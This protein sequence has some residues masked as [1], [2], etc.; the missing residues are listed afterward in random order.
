MRMISSVAALAEYFKRWFPKRNIIIISERKVKHLPVGG[1]TQFV[2]LALLIFGVCWAS[3]STGSFMAARSVLK[4]QRQTLRSVASARVDTNFNTMFPTSE[5]TNVNANAP[6]NPTVTS[7]S[8]PM[9]TLSSLDHNKMFARI[10]FLEH[11]VMELKTNTDAIIRRVSD[12]TSGRISDLESVIRQTGLKVEDLKHE[13]NGGKQ[14]TEGKPAANAKSE[15]GPYIPAAMSS[16]EYAM[17]GNLDKLAV[18]RQIVGNLPLGKPIADA[19]P[20]S[21]FGHRIDPFTGHLAFH[22][23]LDLAGPTGSKIYSTAEGTVAFAGISGAYGNAV[24]IDHGFG[25]TTR[26]GHLSEIRVKEGQTVHKGDVIGI[27]GST[28]RSTGPHLHY[29]VRYHDHPMNP[30][31]FLDAGHYVSEE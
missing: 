31:N 2:T 18:L 26:Y 12:K 27:Q 5:L 30:A 13:L 9:Y 21:P 3:Y 4:E 19:E 17:Y 29:E 8:D 14:A 22:S 7:L 1:K 24:D 28:G 23:G 16:Q 15:G 11:K 10:A 6:G 25:I 20:Q